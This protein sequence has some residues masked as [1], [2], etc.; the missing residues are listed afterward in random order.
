MQSYTRLSR[1]VGIL[2]LLVTLILGTAISTNSVQAQSNEQLLSQGKQV[3]ASSEQVGNEAAKAA[4]G[5]LTASRWSASSSTYPQWWQV[6][7]GQSYQLSK[8]TASWYGTRSYKYTIEVSSDTTTWLKIVDKTTNT[9]VGATSD[10]FAAVGR[11]VRVTST[12]R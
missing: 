7:L 2:T 6:D 4:D 12:L 1:Y 3:I 9:T 11:Y 10:S 8:L 5:N